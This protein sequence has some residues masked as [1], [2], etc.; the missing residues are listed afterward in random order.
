MEEFALSIGGSIGYWQ[1]DVKKLMDDI[2]ELRPTIFVAV[3][4]I[5]E[6]VV[7]SVEAKLKKGPGV[8]RA[9]FGAAFNAKLFLLRQGVPHWLAGL[10]V[11]E[12]LF[13]KVRS[14]LGGSVRLIVSG[15][16][17]LAPHI[18]EFCSTVLAPV[19]QGYGLTETCAGTFI[20]LPDPRMAHSVGPRSPPPSSGWK[21]CPS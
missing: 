4:R 5:L 9:A 7:D 17:P 8:I 15:G 12:I 16:A 18:E 10:G 19:L 14:A 1:R 11:T 2:A 3:P 21:A 13:R 20:M 6:R